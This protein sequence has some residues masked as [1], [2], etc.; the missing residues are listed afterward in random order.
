VLHLEAGDVEND[1]FVGK[2]RVAIGEN[3]FDSEEG[4]ARELLEAN[5]GRFDYD[6]WEEGLNDHE[7][8]TWAD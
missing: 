8:R 2:V 7:L 4:E 1:V 6:L 3:E 5:L